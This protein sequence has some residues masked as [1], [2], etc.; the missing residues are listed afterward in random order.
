MHSG[1][2]LYFAA[3][4]LLCS[5]M[6]QNPAHAQNNYLPAPFVP[7]LEDQGYVV[8]QA[9]LTVP[10]KHAVL[11]PWER[12]PERP[13][14]TPR[15]TLAL[16]K[17]LGEKHEEVDIPSPLEEIYSSRIIEPLT[18]FGYDLFENTGTIDKEKR[19]AM[20][21]GAV[22]DDF[23]LSSGDTLSIIFR[24]QRNSTDTYVIDSQGQLIIEDL[25]PV[26]AAGRTIG[27]V[28]NQL[29]T[30]AQ[31]LH[32]TDV[33][34]SLNEVRQIDVLVVGHVRKPG[35]KTLTV[36][37]TVLDAL[38]D[39]GGIEK[40]GSLRQIKLVRHGRSTVIDLYGLLIHG[41][42][43]M[44]LALQDGDKLI[45]PPIGPTVAVSGGVKRPGIYE[46]TPQLKGMLYKPQ[47]ASEKL[48]LEEMLELSGGVLTPGQNRFIKLGL[49]PDGRETVDDITKPYDPVFSDGSILSVASSRE[50][51]AGTIELTG[52]TRR[53]GIHDLDKVKTLSALLD[54]EQV[55]GPDIYPLI[56][57]IERWDDS[58][59]TGKLLDFPPLLVV[60]GQFDR[61]L[62]DGD[63]VHL[64]SRKQ[65]LELQ[66]P[67]A[68]HKE[69]QELES[70]SALDVPDRITDP[71]MA[72]FL[73]ERAAFIRGAVRQQGAYPLAEGASLEN[74]IAVAGGLTLEAST[75]N[76][77]VTSALHGQN[78]QAHGRSGTQRK[79][80]NFNE[81]DPSEIMLEPGDTVRVNQKFHKI[82]DNSV[83]IIGEVSHPGRY[84]LMPGDK[85]SDLL[86]RAGG[87][88][89]QAYP[90][91]AIFSRES[92]R[93]SEESRFRAAA[94]DL[95]RALAVA[96]EDQD[97]APDANQIGLARQLAAELR[98]VEA[99]GRITVEADP[100]V[101]VTEPELDILLETGD[102]VYI[103]KRPLTVRVNGEVLSPATLQFRKDKNPR[104]Y[105]AEAGNYTYHADKDRVFVLY[106]DGS[107][108]PLLVNNWNH[109]PSFI[110]PGSTIVVPRDPKP[111]D[112]IQ[113]A[114]DITQI[115]SNLAITGIFLDDLRDN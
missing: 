84:D 83:M 37:H 45:I 112:F 75:G 55:L 53:P 106:P 96:M 36:F 38:N 35:R 90:D 64:F 7:W 65:V 98:Q 49:T 80:I 5:L 111:F 40:T 82:A 89:G 69:E 30:F 113:S 86:R 31:Q 56:G 48:T 103:P 6:L 39:S 28:R 74:L 54:D 85:L 19:R 73:T 15:D 9:D 87:L 1:R 17:E 52:H 25:P 27:Q 11:Q 2:F 41:S 109:T 91:G 3:L 44:D 114:R 81:D 18:Q 10:E 66:K 104:D 76:I 26:T 34:V 78:G 60:K 77:E 58:Q 57:V 8:E 70:G 102:R 63:I 33:F 23:L 51:R 108:Q 24:G 61:K 110:P 50:A 22:Q 67:A 4:L 46:I 68:L 105:I 43:N 72:S 101:L 95:E 16:M 100:G 115:L 107:A 14:L 13:A 29:V 59:M 62:E 93:K 97:K 32:N 88:T 71:V 79:N 99:V 42:A 47:D 92:E 12:T 20:P 94:R 21:G